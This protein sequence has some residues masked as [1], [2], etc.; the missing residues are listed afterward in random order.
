MT[1]LLPPPSRTTRRWPTTR[2]RA[3]LAVAVAALVGWGALTLADRW[4]TASH[5]LC[6]PVVGGDAGDGVWLC[7][8]GTAYL[9]P[10]L[11]IGGGTAGAVL[12]AY[13]LLELRRTGSATLHDLADV[14]VQLGAAV[15][16]SAALLLAWVWSTELAPLQGAVAAT[17]LLPVAG[18]AALVKRRRDGRARALLVA[19]TVA[20]VSLGLLLMLVLPLTTAAALCWLAALA[21]RALARRR[22]RRA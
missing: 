13:T 20:A 12:I 22:D 2:Q 15:L 9:W 14:A 7:P 16:L 17:M 6:D 10:L 18:A 1:V 11:L 4:M 5:Y 3:C 19:C 8:D 21:L